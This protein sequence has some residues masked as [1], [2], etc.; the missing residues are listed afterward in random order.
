MD[1]IEKLLPVERL[2]ITPA[3]IDAFIESTVTGVITLGRVQFKG[4]PDEQVADLCAIAL[5]GMMTFIY[6]FVAEHHR[7]AFRQNPENRYAEYLKAEAPVKL[8]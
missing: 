7:D 8:S 1:T 6:H 2:K 4:M 5:D 3:F